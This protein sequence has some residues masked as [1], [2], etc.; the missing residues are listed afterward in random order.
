MRSENV[1]NQYVR[2]HG[3]LPVGPRF[4]ELRLQRTEDLENQVAG[5]TRLCP[6]AG[7]CSLAGAL[8]PAVV[9]RRPTRLPQKGNGAYT[10]HLREQLGRTPRRQRN[11]CES[12]VQAGHLEFP[13]AQLALSGADVER[14]QVGA[15]SCSEVKLHSGVPATINGHTLRALCRIPPRFPPRVIIVRLPTRS[16]SYGSVSMKHLAGSAR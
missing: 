1:I 14:I 6:M 7:P 16:N 5:D 2:S 4:G 8:F 3:G 13:G 11:Q 12:L 15:G 10:E 9:R